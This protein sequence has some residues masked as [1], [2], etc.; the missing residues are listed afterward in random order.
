[1]VYGIYDV[2]SEITEKWLCL[3]N[4]STAKFMKQLSFQPFD[5]EVIELGLETIELRHKNVHIQ[6]CTKTA[7]FFSP[8]LKV[9]GICCLKSKIFYN[10]LT[11]KK[12]KM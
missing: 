6:N 4:V 11:K 3:Q 7:C 12:K 8:S 2:I 5:T 10:T 1:M 9:L